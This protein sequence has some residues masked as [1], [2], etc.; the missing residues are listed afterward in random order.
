MLLSKILDRLEALYGPPRP[1]S[2]TDPFEMILYENVAYLVSD[3]RRDTAFQALRDRVG[4]TA[5]RILSASPKALLLVAE[6]GGMLPEQRVTKLLRS[7]QIAQERFQGDMRTVLKMPVLQ[8]KKSLKL[9]PGIGEPGAEK[10]LLFS[11]ARPVLA[12][13][14]NGLRTL[15]RLGY[16]AEQKSY[17]ATYRSVLEAVKDQIQQDCGWLIRAHQL[18]RRHGQELCKRSQPLCGSCPLTSGCR[19][20]K[21]ARSGRPASLPAG[22]TSSA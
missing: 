18:L 6:L 5:S 1:P 17:A 12:L 19:F 11:G 7:A 10:I 20:Y 8:A 2:I 21:Q 15:I 3:E 22:Y 16:G 4:L 14:S 9:F 13:E